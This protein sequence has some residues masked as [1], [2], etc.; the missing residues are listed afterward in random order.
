[1]HVSSERIP[2]NPARYRA[3]R[4]SAILFVWFP[5]WVVRKSIK[6]GFA[7]MT[8]VVS[9]TGSS[10]AQQPADQTPISHLDPYSD[11][12]LIHPWPIYA[13][14]QDAGPAVWLSKYKMFALAR[15]D[16]A[17][18]ALQDPSSFPSSMGVMMNDHMNHVLRGNTLCSDG[19]DHSRLRRIIMKPLTASALKSLQENVAV[20]ADELVR[21]LVLKGRFCAT[22]DLAVHLPISLVANEVGLAEEGRERMLVW[23]DKMFDC[24]GPE[25]DRTRQALPVLEEM[26][27][28]ATTQAVRGKVK[29][30]SW[31]EAVLDA[32]DRGEVDRSL[33]PVLMIDY[34]GPSLDTTIFGSSSG[35]WL[36]AKYPE[37]WDKVRESPS[38]IPNAIN[39]ILRLE[40][41]IQ[42]FSRYVASDYNMDGITLPA[43]SRAIVFYGAANRDGRQFPDP[44]RFDVTRSNS[45]NHLAFGAGSH[46]CVGINLA[47]LE[48]KAIFGSLAR[49][50]KRFHIEHEERVVNSV[51][52][53]FAK[54]NVSTER[55]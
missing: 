52:R 53:G 28:Y 4:H 24:F 6:R 54:L 2:K 43:G 18:K 47:R 30:G 39:E 33:C 41:P 13:E 11:R 8:T 49:M 17:L 12:A 20:E 40:A 42:G 45:I 5:D 9:G 37:E 34:M 36:F 15:Y 48:M 22:R 14:L 29:P 55:Q 1:M 26:M 31:A 51:L 23:A 19:E 46:V 38:L 3:F 21:R 7:K 16:S 50:V 25:N 10:G 44:H 32:A 27:H 35:V